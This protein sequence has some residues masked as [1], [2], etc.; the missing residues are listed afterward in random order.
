MEKIRQPIVSIMGH[1]DHGKTSLLDNIRGSSVALREPGA[2]TQAIGA[3][4]VPA[5]VIR[6]LCGSLLDSLKIKLSIPGLLF[7]DTPGHAAFTNLRKRGGNLADIAVVVVDINEGLMPQTLETLEILKRYKTPFVF[8][9]NKIDL[10]ERWVDFDG[11]LI[12]KLNH[13][14]P[15]FTQLFETKFYALV[16]KLHE[17]G[18]SVE[19]FD[20]I[21]DFTKQIAMVPVSAKFGVGVPELLMV[22]AGLTQKFLEA[23]LKVGT[24]LFAKGTVLEVKEE[25]GLGTTL[26]VI[27]YDGILKKNDI[28]VIGGLNEPVV[29]K[30]RALLVPKPLTD[31]KDKRVRYDHVD[32]VSAATGVKISAP[33]LDKVLAGMPL[34]SASDASLEEAKAQVQ[35]EVEEV[36]VETD[37]KGV[38]VKADTL[39]SV[40]AVVA[41]L[42]E[43]GV[44]IRSASIGDITKNDLSDAQ[45]NYEEDP[46]SA[47]ILGF[48]VKLVDDVPENVKVIN[49]NVIYKILDEYKAWHVEMLRMEEAKEIDKLVRPCK[50]QLMPNYVFRQNNPMICGTEILAGV[51]K[52]NTP[53]MN[54][55]GDMITNV[56][57]LEDKGESLPKATRGM[58]VAVSYP[59]VTMGRQVKEGDILLSAIPEDHF[60]KF[61]ELK[62]HL[63]E[64]EKDILREVAEIMRRRNVVWGV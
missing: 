11:P 28:I 40:E 26:D 47:V 37:E 8:A 33:G 24:G 5:D 38:V 56:K 53:L 46:F 51:L 31:T 4:I 59:D 3:S 6:K 52:P 2:I 15:R 39:G 41:L 25:K 60:R 16:G 55:N 13:Q 22:M 19:R 62:K 21:D 23:G 18:F 63:T 45:S 54:L 43:A 48:N 34:R 9:V 61:K 1:V 7:I 30:V 44:P 27:L 29:A 64:E 17:L 14:T 10:I 42:R 57:S 50:I 20:R 58:Q 12:A 35:A 32:E 36:I 49:A